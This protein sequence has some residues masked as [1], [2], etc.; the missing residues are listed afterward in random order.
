VSCDVVTRP[1]EPHAG[2]E[3][4]LTNRTN[5]YVLE[6]IAHPSRESAM[7]KFST[8]VAP[9]ACAIALT[10]GLG[11]AGCGGG[12]KP[13]DAA[14][15]PTAAAPAGPSAAEKAL[16]AA[17]AQ[18]A[19]ALAALD[20]EELKK[21]GSQALREQRLYTPAGDNAMEYYLAL[22]KRSEKPDPNAESALMDLQP[23]A[24]IAAE[25]AVGREDW[26]EAER[27]RKLIE[28]A[29]PNAP[30]LPRLATAITD[31]KNNAEKRAAD[32]AALADQQAKAAEEAKK[33]ADEL[34]RQQAEA[35]RTA[36]ATPAAPA[37][38]PDR[39]APTPAAPAPTTA[40]APPPTAPAPAPAP[41]RPSSSALVA[42]S[43][44]QPQY[45]QDALRRGTTGEVV[46]E[47]TVNTDGSVGNITVVNATPRGVFERGVQ[48]TVRRWRFQP[49]AS[50]QTVRR[51]FTF[52]N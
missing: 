32:A 51:T 11:L 34:A 3:N 47:F 25:Q 13:A 14:A 30:A 17:A 15:T 40:A 19:A 43:T 10:L 52:A 5:F 21:R 2:H 46:L 23:Y 31:G 12:D 42:I 50:P 8:P 6:V 4:A 37:P 24:V 7:S 28:A 22:R 27:L 29:D 36:A 16:E 48:N 39:P 41:A 44:P 45:P 26:V 35:A 20:P 18:Q 49:V 9:L 33:R 1:D 38:A